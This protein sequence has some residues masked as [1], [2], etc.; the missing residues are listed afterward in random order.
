MA[1]LNKGKRAPSKARMKL[2]EKE[3]ASRANRY[4][5]WAQD[6]IDHKIS[7]A[8]FK[9]FMKADLKSS[10]IRVALLG[11]GGK[12]LTTRGRKDLSKFLAQS[13]SYL[14]GFI[15]DLTRFKDLSD[16]QTVAR[17]RSYAND[18]GVFTRYTVPA[19]LADLLP[20]LPGID[21]LGQA[22]CGCWLEWSVT[23]NVAEVRWFLL[24]GKEHCVN[25]VS[26]AAEWTPLEVDLPDQQDMDE[27]DWLELQDW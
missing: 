17:A 1:T 18:W 22:L 7:R 25:C 26:F 20:A 10:Q 15:S 16:A 4:G 24:A 14:D 12:K 8:K 27:E 21:C 6:L 9:K 19:V 11:N 2:Y 3:H 5:A 13:Y 23:D